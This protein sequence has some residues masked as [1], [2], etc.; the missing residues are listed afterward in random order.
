MAYNGFMLGMFHLY[1]D[2]KCSRIICGT[3]RF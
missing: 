3:T 2:P 1:G